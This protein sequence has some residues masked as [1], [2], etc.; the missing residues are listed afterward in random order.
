MNFIFL[1]FLIVNLVVQLLMMMNLFDL[2]KKY[3]EYKNYNHHLG[4]ASF[5]MNEDV[6]E[7]AAQNGVMLLQRKDDII[8]TI[9][10]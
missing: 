1:Q 6:K 3:K 9:V 5:N 8:E 7:L 2:H 10:P 4:L